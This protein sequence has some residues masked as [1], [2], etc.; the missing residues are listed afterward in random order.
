MVITGVGRGLGRALAQRWAERDEVWGTT[1]TGT[2]DLPLAGCLCID[3]ADE[4]SIV[5]GAAA[6]R[7]SVPGVDLLVNCAGVDAR[8]FGAPEDP[9]GPFDVPA[10]MWKALF[11]VNVVGPMVFTRELLP[12]LRNG[13]QP[14]VVN[15][16]SQL[17]SMQVAATK[18][19]DTSYC[20]SKA[21]LNM[22]SVKA[23]AELRPAGVG[24]VMLHPGWVQTDMGGRSAPLTIAESADAIV[25]TV[26]A[27]TL[28]DSGRF[29]RWDGTDHPW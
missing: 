14:L 1:R 28:A 8:A 13:S 2:T 26:D 27:L 29:I 18:G 20:V 7:A 6:L 24:V 15:V 12:L 22:F 4:G 21:A 9:R 23:A 11:D 5:A 17:G 3:L 25:A 19:R 16:S 10:H